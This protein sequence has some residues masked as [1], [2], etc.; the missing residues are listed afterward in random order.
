LL[1]FEEGTC[2]KLSFY[3][4]LMAKMMTGET[5]KKIA[6]NCL[7]KF[8]VNQKLKAASDWAEKVTL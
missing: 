1:S 7:H 2:R 6:I 5:M 4:L 8:G 3:G